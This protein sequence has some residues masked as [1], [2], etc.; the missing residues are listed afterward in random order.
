MRKSLLSLLLMVVCFQVYSQTK[1]IKGTVLD[2]SKEPIP[3]A[4]VIIKGTTTGTIT[5]ID[6]AF[7]LKIDSEAAK[8]LVVSSVG[9]VKQEIAIGSNSQFR[10]VLVE[11]NSQLSEVVVVGYGVQKKAL[12]TGANVQVKGENIVNQ[13]TP[14]AMEAL[15]GNTPGVNITRNSGQ[16]GAGTKVTIRGL[17]TNGNSNPLYIVDGVTVGNIDYLNPSDIESINVL[18][19]AAS[20]AIYGSRAANGV[21]LV[22]TKRAT[23]G[24]KTRVNYDGY[25]GVQNIYKEPTPLNAQEYMYIMDERRVNDGLEPFNWKDKIIKGNT[26]LDSQFDGKNIGEQYGQEI[27]NNLKNGWQ[28]TNWVKEILKKNAAIESHALNI[29]GSS[30][31]F[32]F[33][34]GLSYFSQEGIVGGNII[35]SGYKRFTGR[36]NTELVLFKNNNRNFLTVGENFTY[37]NVKNK[38][39][40]TDDIYYNDFH[41]ALG[42]N[43][44]MPV[45]YENETLNKYTNGYAPTLEGALATGHNPVGKM[46]FR[47][48][49][50][51]NSSNNITGNV[52]A[53][54]EPTKDLKIRTS[55]GLT[56]S[57]GNSR[58]YTPTYQLSDIY[59]NPNDVVGQSAFQSTSYTWTNTASYDLKFS[60]HKLGIMVGTE[61][62]R[63][64][65][66]FSIEGS[67][68]NSLYGLP[69]YAYL[70]NT[71][72]IANPDDVTLTSEDV[73]AQGG[74]IMSYMSR[75]SYN[76]NEKYILDATMRADGSSNFAKGN[77]WGYF[78]SVSAGW[79]ISQEGFANDLEW[80]SSAK[81]RGSWG[82][83]GNQSIPRFSYLSVIG[84]VE[85]AYYFGDNKLSPA[86]GAGPVFVPNPDLK[87][88]T[89]EQLNFGI[90]ARFLKDRL[91]IT[92]DWYK[93]TTK[94]WLVQAPVLGTYGLAA[95]TINGGDVL[96]QGY[97][98]SLSWNDRISDFKYNVNLNVA[99]NENRVTR[100]ANAEGTLQ[101]K[102]DVLAQ[103]TSDVLRAEV[104]KPLGFF[105]GHQTAGILQNQTDVDNYVTK[106]GKPIVIGTEPNVPR[107]PG[108]LRFVDLNE[109]GIIDDNDKTM[110]GKPRPDFEF[111]M[112]LN[113]EYKGFYVNTTLTG[114]A[115]L[116]VMQSY[117]TYIDQRENFTTEVF[118]RWH[119]EGTSNRL[120]RL[121]SG[122]SANYSL[123]SDIY[124]HDADYLRISNLTIGYK[125]DNLLKRMKFIQAASI[126]SSINNLYTFTKYSGMN[127]EVG[128]NAGTTWGSGIDLGL[129]PFARTVMFGLNVTF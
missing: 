68:K 18:K 54:L 75:L 28:G 70:K 69:K 119:G 73:A 38:T 118:N 81:L 22:T 91:G 55:Y 116:Q 107:R 124:V 36:Y 117:R 123:I 41:D 67:I 58:Y 24:A 45:R 20:A 49:S 114:K 44:L 86:N 27:W 121:S 88:E 93:K 8:S 125:L 11:N 106:D 15:Q 85:N 64:I 104:G 50:R 47:N 126:Y 16:P 82:Q 26:S 120:P 71:E 1:T 77:R 111:G 65:L 61:L 72:K 32:T 4:N 6:G 3:G 66:D 84:P 110:I 96:N 46:Y 97:E 25:Y 90:D 115:G 62:N 43:P 53:L 87:W 9:F 37:T 33:A 52:Y 95:P 23:K 2:V 109:D 19:D 29:T 101:G 10:I 108:D 60:K 13:R 5:D 100:L 42:G 17:G 12:V 34:G 51:W 83:N 59:S 48:N 92:F 112:Q 30:G 39:V 78:P 122:S 76:Y 79:N 89:S 103:G 127:P 21:I 63:D 7:T 35:N 31:D 94:D 128:Y 113:A 102:R 57:F 129:Y 105:Y 74:G 98:I 56:S 40:A 99:R 80:L 14:S